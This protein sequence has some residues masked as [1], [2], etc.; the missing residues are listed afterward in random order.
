MGHQVAHE[1]AAIAVAH[2]PFLA[3]EHRGV[4]RP[5]QGDLGFDQQRREREV[6]DIADHQQV[7]VAACVGGAARH[8]PVDA[9]V[10]DALGQWRQRVA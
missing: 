6:I 3:T 7:D 4:H 5:S 9:G 8:R 2:A 1:A 10:G